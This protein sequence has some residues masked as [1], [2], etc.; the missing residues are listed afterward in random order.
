MPAAGRALVERG[1]IDLLPSW[2]A[3]L[4]PVPRVRWRR[5]RFGVDPAVILAG[6][7]ARHTGLAVVDVLRPATVGP[8]HAGRGRALRTP[9]RYRLRHACPDGSILVDDVVTT[10]GTL[11]AAAATVGP[12]A[13]MA[14]TATISP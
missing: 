13:R 14:L 12:A 6:L 2:A 11:C 7:L 4:I 1:M 8:T 3:A 9:P 5:A 10:G